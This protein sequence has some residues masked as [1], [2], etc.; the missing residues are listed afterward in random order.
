MNKPNQ[1]QKIVFKSIFILALFALSI[2]ALAVWTPAPGV[3]T[4]GNPNP[5]VNVGLAS[6]QKTGGLVVGGFRS[7]G[8]GIFDTNVTVGGTLS[9]AGGNP[10]VN[11][12][13]S[14]DAAGLASW[15]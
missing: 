11:K 10:G 14:S 8:I 4:G 7:L 3:P 15:H 13:L 5:P 6:Q 1:Q 12:I 2:Q 9:I